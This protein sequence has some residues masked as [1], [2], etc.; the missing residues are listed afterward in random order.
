MGSM[1]NVPDIALDADGL[2]GVGVLM[3]GGSQFAGDSYVIPVGGTSA[4]APEAAAMWALVLQACKQTAKCAT[5]SGPVPYRLGNPNAYFYKIYANAS[6]YAST[7][8]DVVFGSNSLYCMPTATPCPTPTD[9]GYESGK[10]YD[11]V[12]G[13]GAPFGRALI[14]AVVGI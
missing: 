8:Y 5:A 3:Y 13:V 6:T 11:L 12:T 2:T 10:G 7:F 4:A 9:P 1:R 14:K